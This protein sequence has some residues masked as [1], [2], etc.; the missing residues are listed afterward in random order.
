M[1]PLGDLN[2][3][4]GANDTG[5]SRL[6]RALEQDL[7]ALPR[8]GA[9]GQ[10][11]RLSGSVL[12]FELTEREM[13]NLFAD[14]TRS[15][16]TDPGES[17]ERVSRRFWRLGAWVGGRLDHVAGFRPHRGK[18]AD[19]WLA[20][21]R[22][23]APD[24]PGFDRVLDELGRSRLVA[25]E[26]YLAHDQGWRRW[27]VSWC[28]PPL[29]RLD[30]E[31][32][33]ALEASDL[34]RFRPASRKRGL[35][36]MLLDAEGTA[37][38]L[39]VPDA[40][41][42]VAPI[43][44]STALPV[45]EP[46]AVP[47]EFERVFDRVE[48]RVRDLVL[49]ARWG[50]EDADNVDV[51]PQPDPSDFV[52]REGR[53]ALLE[54]VDGAAQPHPDAVAA[55]SLMGVA[56]RDALPPFIA[57]RY[58]F[59]VR[60]RP[61]STWLDASAIELML[62][63]RRSEE[64][65]FDVASVAD[66]YRL[67]LQLAILEGAE[68]LGRLSDTI[69]IRIADA[70][71]S[72]E[73]ATSPGPVD[74]EPELAELAERD[75]QFFEATLH[76]FREATNDPGVARE[77]VAELAV[78]EQVVSGVG[79]RQLFLIDEPERH[80]HPRLQRHAARWLAESVGQ[81]RTPTVLASH[82]APFLGLGEPASYLHLDRSTAGTRI[83]PFTPSDRASLEGVADALGLDRGE[84]LSTTAAWLVVEGPT[85]QAVLER[86]FGTELHAAGIV[87]VPLHGTANWRGILEAEALWRFVVVPVAVMFDNVSAERVE[88]L[89]HKTDA[90]LET[91][92]RAARERPE[93]QDMAKLIRTARQ[94]G[95]VVHPVP[96]PRPDML[97]HLDEDIL[98]EHFAD[99][100]GHEEA[101]GRWQRH[102]RGG[103]G[104]FFAERFGIKKDLATFVAVAEAMAEKGQR[105]EGLAEIVRFCTELSPRA[106]TSG[107]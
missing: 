105:P 45:P 96:N 2:V 7:R 36:E 101:E 37:E 55:L 103:R 82:S 11:G 51:V 74:H 24:S 38:H 100:P 92:A 75:F 41:V 50:W 84:L 15:L 58:E 8:G 26:P 48:K 20:V 1:V 61:V 49:V 29:D 102:N 80:L 66:G 10:E 95:R 97:S 86:L 46:L 94:H 19:A 53:R 54:E 72:R 60:F 67:W 71:A 12:F 39:M 88:E 52:E 62:K 42:I 43:G 44:R 91:I 76:R 22:E 27:S 63:N 79:P 40:P 9:R 64:G 28:L 3:L 23:A 57:E 56:A 106:R 14:A 70:Y 47:T 89:A 25:L 6:L 5:K 78:P 98:R 77:L 69:E 65:E 85:D 99:F 68:A 30:S 35:H 33:A 87:I 81:R 34:R 90:E 93:V 18:E 31:L 21:L 107:W 16:R 83:A 4:I 17:S 59:K 32:V 104:R 13:T 73:D